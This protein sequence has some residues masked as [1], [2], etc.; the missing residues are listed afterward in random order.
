MAAAAGWLC[1]NS[2]T[3]VS[4]MQ[5]GV[6]SGDNGGPMNAWTVCAASHFV[7]LWCCCGDAAV[8]PAQQAFCGTLPWFS[9]TASMPC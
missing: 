3:V 4:H 6:T 8:G 2:F 7:F 9:D 5:H 1:S